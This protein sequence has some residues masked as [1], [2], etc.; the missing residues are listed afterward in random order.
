MRRAKNKPMLLDVSHRVY[1]GCLFFYPKDLR[2]DF[3]S[4]MIEVFD[5]Q[6]LEAYSLAGTTAR[7]V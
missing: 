3:G 4:E 5:E 6:T 2:R 1:E 7:L